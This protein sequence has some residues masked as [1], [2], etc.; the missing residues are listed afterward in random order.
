MS[1]FTKV[2]NKGD[3]VCFKEGGKVEFIKYDSSYNGLP[4]G[5]TAVGVVYE[6]RGKNVR[7]LHKTSASRKWAEV[8]LWRVV[9]TLDGAA[10][11]ASI[12]SNKVTCSFT[13]NAT[14]IEALASQIDAAV[15]GYDFG[16]H[17][18]TCY[19]RNG[20]VVLQH[21][22]YTTYQA[23]TATGLTVSAW[24]APEL[25]ADSNIRRYNGQ[26]VSEGAI[27]NL[28]RGLIYFNSDNSSASYN[29]NADITT[30]RR[31][32]PICKPGYLGTSQYQSDHCT[33]LRAIYG[34]GQEGWENYIR[35]TMA[36][37]DSFD[38]VF[39][40][41]DGHLNTYKLA[42]QTYIK[43]DGS[44]GVLY[45]ALDYVA[46]AGYNCEGLEMGKWYLPTPWEQV[47]IIRSTTYPAVYKNG[48]SVSVARADADIVNRALNAIGGTAVS[49]N[50]T[51][52]SS[53]RCSTNHAWL[54]S[55]NGGFFSISNFYGSNSALPVLLYKLA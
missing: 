43:S 25:T 52:W 12:T 26:R 53:C 28:D 20:E 55:G 30:P 13:Y 29:P 45:P 24:V 4:S 9:G 41:K 10:H 18:Y 44:V 42:G 3:I 15:R 51:A 27:C 7:I 23:V 39:A 33:A 35:K 50:V 14:T 16:G 31:P 19:V 37:G 36:I 2:P 17:A 54:Y 5:Y 38:G 21:N 48:V 22:T 49:N 47:K 1:K 8:F 11:S 40:Q 6:R 32:Y 46:T 34:E